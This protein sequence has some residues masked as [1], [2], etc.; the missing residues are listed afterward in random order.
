MLLQGQTNTGNICRGNLPVDFCERAQ[1]C[2]MLPS[3]SHWKLFENDW[4][5]AHSVGK[6]LQKDGKSCKELDL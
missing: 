1:M 3:N 6:L 2:P 4:K 5:D